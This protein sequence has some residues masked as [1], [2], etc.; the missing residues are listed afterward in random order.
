MSGLSVGV[1]AQKLGG[2]VLESVRW[3]Q[4]EW[5]SRW[6]RAL[7]FMEF[8]KDVLSLSLKWPEEK[9]IGIQ[10]SSIHAVDSELA[11]AMRDWCKDFLRHAKEAICELVPP[12]LPDMKRGLGV[13]VIGGPA[14]IDV[15]PGGIRD[16]HINTL[17]RCSGRVARINTIQQK[18]HIGAWRCKRCGGVLRIECPDVELVE[19]TI[20]VESQGGCGK[21]RSSTAWDLMEEESK[22]RNLQVVHLE[23]DYDPVQGAEPRTIAVYLWDELVN[24]PHAVNASFIGVVRAR[25]GRK[26]NTKM[27]VMDTYIDAIS[28]EL[29]SQTRAL[30]LSDDELRRIK[31]LASKPPA[32]LFSLMVDSFCPKVRGHVKEKLA[33]VLQQFG[34]VGTRYADGTERRGDSHIMLVGDPGSGKSELLKFAARVAPI[35]S[36]GS[37]ESSSGPGLTCATVPDH[38]DGGFTVKPGLLPMANGGLVS[39]DEFDK[40]RV[41]ARQSLHNALE[42]QFIAYSKAG[43]SGKLACKVSL[44][45]AANPKSGRFRKDEPVTD[46]FDLSGPMATRFDLIFPI[47]DVVEE[48]VDSAIAKHI[49]E[50]VLEADHESEHEPPIPLPLFRKY[51]AYAKENIRPKMTEEAARLIEERYVA[52]RARGKDDSVVAATPRQ[53]HAIIRL[54]QASAKARLSDTVSTEDVDRG[55]DLVDNYLRRVLSDINGRIDIDSIEI[56]VPSSQHERMRAIREVI[57]NWQ[58]HE[59]P[60]TELTLPQTMLERRGLSIDVWERD[61]K[62]LIEKGDVYV[63]SDRKIRLVN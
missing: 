14:G 44:L 51:I 60:M 6:D 24:I 29:D 17:V 36:F 12:D 43:F 57:R 46:Q 58:P 59:P 4:A 5:R 37:G 21:T 20:C 25:T 3:T 19:P 42:D 38:V 32:D 61:I 56:G 47:I 23:E 52:W 49:T 40:L 62:L 10:W 16:S 22:Y 2:G 27:A 18:L 34:G 33:L 41:R 28:Y 39:L 1:A 26:G 15:R 55:I 54:T 63:G 48:T 45:A 9:T 35:A 8:S 30:N 7:L 31:A 13:R 50:T 53:I 11:E